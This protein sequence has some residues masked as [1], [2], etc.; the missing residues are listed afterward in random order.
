MKWFGPNWDAPVCK[1]EDRVST[2]K[3][4][5]IACRSPFELTSRG[6]ILP[7]CGGEGDPSEVPYHVECLARSMGL[8]PGEKQ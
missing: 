3:E 1:L 7:F 2:P 5:C 4:S 8:I 6:L